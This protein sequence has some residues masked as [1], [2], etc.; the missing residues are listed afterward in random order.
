MLTWIGHAN[1][2][3][4]PV[5]Q[6]WTRKTMEFAICLS[7]AQKKY[8]ENAILKLWY[9]HVIS[10][11]SKS[12]LHSLT[13]D[14]D[15]SLNQGLSNCFWWTCDQLPYTIM[16]FF[17]YKCLRVIVFF[18]FFFFLQDVQQNWSLRLCN[19]NTQ[20]F[21]KWYRKRFFNRV[22]FFCYWNRSFMPN[23]SPCGFVR[24]LGK[25][26]ALS[27]PKSLTKPQGETLGINDLQLDRTS[28]NAW[29]KNV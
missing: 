21:K 18:F 26:R 23:V 8:Q 28:K 7:N 12:S 5:T 17:A 22:E 24:D 6:G 1:E 15:R 14:S 4:S 9:I 16:T 11:S 27:F 25:E 10:T 19:S 29:P 2:H 13:S 20:N 3:W